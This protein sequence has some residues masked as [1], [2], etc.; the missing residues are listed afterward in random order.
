MD[1]SQ[2]KSKDTQ[3]KDIWHILSEIKIQQKGSKYQ[4]HQWHTKHQRKNICEH[5]SIKLH[6]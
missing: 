6:Q 3:L 4:N 5:S 1:S 2:L